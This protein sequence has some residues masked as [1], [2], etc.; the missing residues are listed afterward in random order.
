MMW[1]VSRLVIKNPLKIRQKSR[2]IRDCHEDLSELLPQTKGD[3]KNESGK[4]A[5]VIISQY[6]HES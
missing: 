4:K 2:T 6:I 5:S 3:L 1:P